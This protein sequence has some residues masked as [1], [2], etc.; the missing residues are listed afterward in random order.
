[1]LSRVRSVTFSYF[2]EATPQS[3]A[4]WHDHWLERADLPRLIKVQV[5][6]TSGD[7]RRWPEL[8]ISPLIFADVACGYD[9]LTKNC[10]G[11]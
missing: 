5:T 9:P 11:R 1:L 10:R 2:G 6:F 3:A 8:L 4:G 7:P